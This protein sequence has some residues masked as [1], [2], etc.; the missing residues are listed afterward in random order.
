MCV[1]ASLRVSGVQKVKGFKRIT[2]H[3]SGS[4]AVMGDH[5]LETDQWLIVTQG[6]LLG[7][8]MYDRPSIL[9]HSEHTHPPFRWYAK[10]TFYPGSPHGE[11]F[12]P[13]TLLKLHRWAK[14]PS[15]SLKIDFDI[16]L[17]FRQDIRVNFRLFRIHEKIVY[18][19]N[20]YIYAMYVYSFCCLFNSKILFELKIIF[21]FVV[22]LVVISIIVLS[23]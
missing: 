23:S 17:L 22:F 15:V 11:N 3:S 10:Q 5:F 2:Q 6:S 21:N 4:L 14:L 7:D 12:F 13:R 20:I 19:I 16:L 18:V 9:F 8:E 1:R